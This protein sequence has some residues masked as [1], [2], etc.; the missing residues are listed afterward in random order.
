MKTVVLGFGNPILSDDAVGI[1][2]AQQIKEQRP[3]LDVVD[4]C[5]AGLTILEHVAGYDKLI[6]IDSIK[7]G[8]GNPGEL[9]QIGLEDFK[10]ATEIA[11][12]HGLDIA[13]VLKVGQEMGYKIPA[14][15]SIYAVEIKDNVTFGE[16]C[17]E[18]VEQRIPSLTEQIM[19]E[20]KL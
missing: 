16:E 6:I 10:P 8:T 12:S 14:A 15:V 3:Q 7:N 9:Y 4:T 20:E 13:T 11:T 1:R 2:I 5:E 17:T 18:E 19:R